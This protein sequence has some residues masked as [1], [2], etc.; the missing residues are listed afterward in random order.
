[1]DIGVPPAGAVELIRKAVAVVPQVRIVTVSVGAQWDQA[2][3]A[4]LR[5][6]AIGHIDKDTAPDR[7]ARLVAL[8]ADGEAILPRR[9]VTRV[10]ASWRMRPL[11][12][13]DRGAAA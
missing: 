10:L 4:A 3:L 8:A 2:V 5:A 6:G 11:A 7:I 9:L 12:A 13:D 1:V